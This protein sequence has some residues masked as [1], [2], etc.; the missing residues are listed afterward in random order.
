MIDT[1]GTQLFH[2]TMPFTE[3]LGIEVLEHGP[4]VVRSRLAWDESL[5]TLGGALHGGVLMALADATGAVCAYLNLPAGKQGTTT[6]ESKTNFL[7]AVRSGH[8]VA[9]SRPLH[10]GRTLIVVET[11][12]HD[13]TAKL[14]AKITQTQAVL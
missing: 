3:K 1:E 13:T 14:V 12:I 11:E 7:R 9:T 2:T 8:A 6:V 10:T 4:E 5:C